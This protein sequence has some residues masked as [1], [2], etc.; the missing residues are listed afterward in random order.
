MGII[1]E[2][3]KIYPTGKVITYYK[4][5]G[6]D[7]KHKQEL[8]VRIKDLSLCSTALVRVECDYCGEEREPM[9]YVDYNTQTKNGT[10]KC[11][12]LNCVPLKRSEVIFEKYGYENATQVPEIKEKIRKTNQERYGSNSP[13]GNAEVREKQKKTLMEHYGVENPSLSKEIQDKRTQT[14]IENYGVENPMLVKEIREKVQHTIVE[15]YGVENISQNPEIQDKRTQTFI[16]RYGASTPLQN[17]ECLEKMKQTNL[18]RYGVEFIPQLEETKQKVK[19]TNLE[20]CGY[21]SYMRS[22][23]FLEK[24]F[25]K[26]GSNFVRTSRQQRYLCSLYNGILNHPFKCFALD[27]FL[28]EDKLDVEFDGSGHRMSIFLGSITE[29]DFEKKELYRNVALKKEGYNRMRIISLHDFLP[30]D[31]I[32]FQML[33]D[34]RNYF[35]T[36]QH[37]WITYDIDKSLLFNAENK[38]GA[39]YSYGLLRTIKESDLQINNNVINQNNIVKEDDTHENV[40]R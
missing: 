31:D 14:F 30:Q 2:T 9:R 29:E 27:V 23:E 10:K 21:E 17:K 40:L 18:E 24:W 4:E 7:T 3:V 20:N 8:E 38:D 39:P 35:Q 13:A 16:K 12:C 11:C 19:K 25:S 36:T 15:R 5:K 6:Y 33:N 32:L 1:S 26:H 22:P 28:P 37:T 34:A